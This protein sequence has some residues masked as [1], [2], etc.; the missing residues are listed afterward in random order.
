MAVAGDLFILEDRQTLLGQEVL[1]VYTY[2]WTGALDPSFDTASEQLATLFES[3][4]LPAILAVQSSDVEHTSIKVIN[5]FDPTDFA[6]VA[7]S[8]TGDIPSATSELLPPANAVAFQLSSSTRAVRSGAKRIA[9]I[10]EGVQIDGV[11]TD[12]D[13][14]LDLTTLAGQLGGIIFTTETIPQPAYQPII[15]KRVKTTTPSGDK[16][17]WPETLAQFV[18][19]LIADVIFDLIISTQVTRKIGRGQ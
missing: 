13:Y 15:V 2:R 17:N 7:V 3:Q 18:F 8:E 12:I 9:G 5:Q 4:V 19:S 14:T 16:Y 1:N 10:P 11:I 6:I